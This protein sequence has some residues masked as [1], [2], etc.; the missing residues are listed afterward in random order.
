LKADG[1]P[2]TLPMLNFSGQPVTRK[3]ADVVF[4]RMPANPGGEKIQWPSNVSRLD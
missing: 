1:M 3:N 4:P 2:F